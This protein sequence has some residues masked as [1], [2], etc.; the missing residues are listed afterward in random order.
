M[1]TIYVNFQHYIKR[2]SRIRR[3]GTVG[4]DLTLLLNFEA[5]DIVRAETIEGTHIKTQN[6]FYGL[7]LPATAAR[8][9]CGLIIGGQVWWLTSVIPAL[10]EAEAGRSPEIRSSSPACLT[11]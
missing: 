2:D 11:W 5:K 4:V 10:W 6:L 7:I 8:V 9:S 1:C 3:V